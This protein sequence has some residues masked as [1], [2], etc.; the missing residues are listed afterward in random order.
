MLG[1]VVVV[2]IGVPDHAGGQRHVSD[3]GAGRVPHVAQEEAALV[4][5]PAEVP[6]AE[7]DDGGGA[8]PPPELFYAT[9]AVDD[10]HRLL[11]L[12]PGRAAAE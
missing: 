8:A 11:E 6:V 7:R 10:G 2:D 1:H 5:D 4:V 3:L 12:P 9:V